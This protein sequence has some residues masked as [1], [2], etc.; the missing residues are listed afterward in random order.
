MKTLD[1][2]STDILEA[3]GVRSRHDGVHELHGYVMA[4]RFCRDTQKEERWLPAHLARAFDETMRKVRVV[5]C[6]GFPPKPIF[7]T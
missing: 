3:E 1:Q 5:N 7:I 6:T 4:L 2:M